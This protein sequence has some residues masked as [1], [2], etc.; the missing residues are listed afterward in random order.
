MNNNFRI[1][2]YCIFNFFYTK[3]ISQFLYKTCDI[4]FHV[5]G[6]GAQSPNDSVIM[7]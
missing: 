6:V 3:N 7:L 1:Y 5:S 2:N 4:I